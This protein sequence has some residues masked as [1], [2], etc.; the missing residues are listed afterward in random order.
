MLRR[1]L[2]AVDNSTIGQQVFEEALALARVTGASMMLLYVLDPEEYWSPQIP[3]M[4]YTYSMS[5]DEQTMKL[6]QKQWQEFEEQGLKRLQQMADEAI[7]AGVKTEFTQK[8][9]SPSKV[10]C[11][12]ADSWG[13]DLIVMGRRGLSGI[14]EFFL[15][16]VSNYVLHRAPCSVHIVH[17]HEIES[18]KQVPM[19]D[20]R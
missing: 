18:G 7:G 13:A 9:G 17:K 16:S 1:I 8:T 11:T 3:A 10:I 5:L 4:Y 6:Y 12:I 15:G 19:S 14:K 20:E 2:V